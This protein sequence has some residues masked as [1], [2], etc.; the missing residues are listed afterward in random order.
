MKNLLTVFLETDIDAVECFTPAPM[1]KCTVSDARKIWN[2][3]VTIWGGIPAIMLSSSVPDEEFS[4]YL[5]EIAHQIGPGDHF[6]FGVGDNTPI[7]AD[8]ERLRIA[9]DF[10]KSLVLKG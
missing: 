4:A 5:K 7:D 10:V 8:P 6:I 9:D 1:T 2:G 3:R